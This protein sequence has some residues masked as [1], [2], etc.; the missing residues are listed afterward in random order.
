[1]LNQ[2]LNNRVAK[3]YI[4]LQEQEVK[5]LM[6]RLVDQPEKFLDHVRLLSA[7]IALRVAYGYTV[8]SF[9]DPFM[10][11]AEK[12]AE[13]FS[14]FIQPWSYA[15]NII[16]HL[17]YL[18]DWLPIA[19]FQRRVIELRKVLSDLRENPF[20]YVLEQ[21]AEGT[22]ENS[23]VSKLLQT[24]DGVS[25]DEETKEDIK[26][27]AATF[28]AAASDTTV[29]GVQSF[30]LAMTL[31][32]EA[33]A[34][35][36]AEIAS[37]LGSGPRR[38]I[39][40]EDRAGLPYTS[41]LLKEVQRWHPIVPVI[42]HRSSKDDD[43]NVICGA[44]TYMIPAKSNIMVN[45]WK[46]LHDPDV[47]P[48]PE[49]FLPERFLVESPPPGPEE[50]T[51]GF[52]RRICPGMHVGQQSMWI[53][54]SNLLSN[55]TIRKSKDCNGDD[56]VPKEEYANGMVSHPKPF[57]CSVDVRDGCRDWIQDMKE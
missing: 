9:E 44:K 22:A 23:F 35:A 7:S 42:P 43:E 55:F 52:G 14:D 36:Q 2:A 46:I 13:G 51:F 30:F 48:N 28:Y 12:W 41:A 45:V 26:G 3:D 37:Y 24:E 15:V 25:V 47:Y 31:Y 53:S 34:K 11:T 1:M 39:L 50:Y 49:L 38:I 20:R 56:I 8:K 27:M 10:Q 17:R 6:K 57:V 19:P 54:I 16:P 5:K 29:S 33:Q 40:P 32:P 18:P 4:P 21:M